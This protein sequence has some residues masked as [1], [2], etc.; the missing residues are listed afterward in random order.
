MERVHY[1]AGKAAVI[2]RGVERARKRIALAV[3]DIESLDFLAA[4]GGVVP[5][6]RGRLHQQGVRAEGDGVLGYL[7]EI[8]NHDWISRD[9]G[10]DRN[11]RPELEVL[12]ARD[13]GSTDA[14]CRAN[15]APAAAGG[16]ARSEPAKLLLHVV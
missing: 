15:R 4:I 16:R 7:P 10:A 2:G 3:Q 14:K 5:S 6:G 11:L 1:V 13:I 8:E 9:P 12:R